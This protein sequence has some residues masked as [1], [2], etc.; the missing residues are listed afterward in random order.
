M[1]RSTLSLRSALL[2]WHRWF[3]LIAAAWLAVLGLTGAILVFYEEI[4]RGLNP[5]WRAPA[6]EGAEPR[7]DGLIAAAERTQPGGFVRFVDL[8]DGPNEPARISFGAR[9]GVSTPP[10]P[11][12]LQVF[13][14]PHT[15]E[16]LGQRRFG[17]LRFDRPHLA[18][19]V[20]QLHINLMMGPVFTWLAG[21]LAFLWIFDHLASA[22]LSFPTAAKWAQSFRIRAGARGHKL[23]FDLHRAVGLWAFPVTLV[24]AVSGVYF[25]WYEDF[26]K[27]VSATMPT[28]AAYS[29]RAPDLK[30]PIYAP[31]VSA[32]AAIAIATGRTGARVDSILML[33]EKGLHEVRL[34]DP[35]DV[36][37][38][39]GR[40]IYVDM[41]SGTVA[42][43]EHDTEG[44]AGNVV[45]AWQYPL[46]SG[47]AFGW[48]GRIAILLAGLAVAMFSVTGVMIW[49]RKRSARLRRRSPAADPAAQPVAAE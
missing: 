9:E 37:P 18:P 27:A 49:A 17:A 29:E 5:E 2:V 48:P 3:G 16:I 12:G 43:D 30:A 28:T 47:K 20:Y 15:G 24:L 6:P 32:D 8:P 23:V 35:R 11:S 1:T 45:L 36:E 22:V 31:S 39:G 21:L 44:G 7:L 13:G 34:F 10:P 19:L 38:Y 14:D 26:K 4:D 33:P 40:S 25:N 41:R 42:A 46:H